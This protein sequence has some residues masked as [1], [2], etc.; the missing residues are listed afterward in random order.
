ML[1]L[2]LGLRLG[3]GLGLV[4]GSLVFGKFLVLF[5]RIR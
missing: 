4:F 1:V 2:E 3:S 5:S